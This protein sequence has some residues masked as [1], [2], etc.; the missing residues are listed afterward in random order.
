MPRCGILCPVDQ[1]K[2][3]DEECLSCRT[4]APRAGE[5]CVFTFEMLAGMM[6]GSGRERAHVSATMLTSGCPRRVVLER[7][8]DWHANPQTAFAAW[9]GTMG[10][11]MTERHPEPG[12]VY[13]QRFETELAIAGRKQKITGQVDKID[14]NQRLITDFKTK[15]ESKLKRLKAPQ[16]EHVLQL[17]IYRWL[18]TVG[19]PQ[20]KLTVGDRVYVPRKPAGIAIDRLRLV[21][22]SMEGP[23]EMEA[24]LMELDEVEAVV[25]SRLELLSGLPPVPDD[26]DPWKSVICTKWCAVRDACVAAQL[27]F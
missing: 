24:P 23:K 12:C 7:Q 11:A 10:H 15:T 14:L 17:N 20:R 2:I 25:R 3:S 5:H 8:T 16:P 26:L 22:W 13:E 1:T 4:G 27:G 9:R 19:W 21:Y 18:L 6:D